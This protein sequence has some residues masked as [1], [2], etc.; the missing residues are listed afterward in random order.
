MLDD[1]Q[2][3]LIILT[4]VSLYKINKRI[5]GEYDTN[6][7]FP[8][9]N[10]MVKFTV[11]SLVLYL[12]YNNNNKY[13]IEQLLELWTAI[14]VILLFHYQFIVVQLKQYTEDIELEELLQNK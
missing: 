8:M 7:Y 14:M 1:K 4:L 9:L 6:D 11:T 13:N 10:D 2:F 3:V 5:E 12:I